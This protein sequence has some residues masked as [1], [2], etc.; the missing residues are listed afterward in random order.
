[1]E[2]RKKKWEKLN[3]K[4]IHCKLC[5]RLVKWRETVAREKRRAYKDQEYWGK[6]V[7]G[8]G[9]RDARLLIV[10]LAPGAHGSNRT[11]RMFTGDASGDFL[12]PTLYQAGF[13]SQ[14]ISESKNDSLYLTN[15]LLRLFVVVYHLRINLHMRK[16]RIAGGF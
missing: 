8:F 2:S 15:V 14:P 6:P 3:N 13:A 10:G 1:M 16:C 9:D 7:P 12:Y 11:G 5:P 4:L